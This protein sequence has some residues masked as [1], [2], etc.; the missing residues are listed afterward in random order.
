MTLGS[1]HK[2]AADFGMFL[3]LA[4][5]QHQQWPD[6]RLVTP[7]VQQTFQCT[8]APR[9]QQH[10][11]SACGS[12]A[13]VTLL[14]CGVRPW[15]RPRME[16][17]S[18]TWRCLLAAR[19]AA[20]LMAVT[21]TCMVLGWHGAFGWL[22]GRQLAQRQWHA[23]NRSLARLYTHFDTPKSAVPDITGLATGTAMSQVQ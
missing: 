4:A 10:R 20:L 18:A 22:T 11:P 15:T 17:P 8:G 19:T 2:Q 9:A 6:C 23:R 3:P 1:W 7:Q 13:V 14:R 21:Q 16:A 5:W 12:R